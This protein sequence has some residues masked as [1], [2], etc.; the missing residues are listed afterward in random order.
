MGL[1][2]ELDESLWISA[3]SSVCARVH[4]RVRAE[5]WQRVQAEGTLY[6]LQIFDQLPLCTP[7]L[8]G[9]AE[10]SRCVHARRCLPRDAPRGESR[11]WR[12][13]GSC[14]ASP[15]HSFH[16]FPH[17]RRGQT[18]PWRSPPRGDQ[19]VKG[20]IPS[21]F[22][23]SNWFRNLIRKQTWILIRLLL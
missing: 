2:R 4:R 9:S 10:P 6:S 22:F 18:L 21:I 11:G 23:Y 15:P 19:E 17:C 16:P 5:G 20:T 14:P 7:C 1:N 13:C 8:Q 3:E 12:G